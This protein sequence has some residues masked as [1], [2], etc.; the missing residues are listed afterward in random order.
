[1]FTS[2]EPAGVRELYCK[3]SHWNTCVQNYATYFDQDEVG[4][5]GAMLHMK[6]GFYEINVLRIISVQFSPVQVM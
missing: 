3:Q 1:M 2:Q 4:R 5:R 6:F